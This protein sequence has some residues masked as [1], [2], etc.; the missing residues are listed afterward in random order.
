MAKEKMTIYKLDAAMKP[1][2]TP[3][4][5][6]YFNPTDYTIETKN[7]YQRTQ[8]PGLPVPTTQFISGE[9]QTISLTLLFDTYD[10]DKPVKED[11]RK[12]TKEIMMLMEIDSSLHHPPVCEFSWG[13]KTL[14]SVRNSFKGVID[15]CSQ[16]YTMF[17]ENGTPV[18]ATLTLS[19]SEYRK[20]DEQL[21]YIKF[22]SPDR[23]KYRLFIEGDALWLM[24]FREY[25]DQAEW[26]EI[27]NANNIDNPRL[28]E[29]GISLVLPPLE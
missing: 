12:Y 26:R 16:K 24:A 27:A 29:P 2:K 13:G 5:A 7:Q 9:T 18:R 4:Y 8:L 25:N 10:T 3:V 6:G 1:S 15:S 28:I 22:E 20:I 17:A 21:E 23:S 11:V 14:S 19:I